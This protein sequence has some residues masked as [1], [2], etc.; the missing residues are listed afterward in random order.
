MIYRG[1]QGRY[2]ILKWHGVARNYIGNSLETI[3]KEQTILFNVLKLSFG[4]FCCISSYILRVFIFLFF[5][6]DAMYCISPN[7]F[8]HMIFKV[9]KIMC[10]IY[11]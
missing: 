1:F 5:I 9:Y 3:A 8:A 4:S 2:P 11:I 7:A 10:D 6:Y